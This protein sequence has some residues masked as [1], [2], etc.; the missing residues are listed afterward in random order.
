M[1]RISGLFCVF[2]THLTAGFADEEG[3]HVDLHISFLPCFSSA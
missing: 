2:M 3:S 1:L